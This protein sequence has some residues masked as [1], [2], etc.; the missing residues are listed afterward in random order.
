MSRYQFIEQVATTEPVQVLCRVLHVSPAGY[1]QWRRRAGRPTP[2]WE[3]AATAAFS[4]HA[5]R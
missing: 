4:R 2:A 1:Y 3:S 5:Q